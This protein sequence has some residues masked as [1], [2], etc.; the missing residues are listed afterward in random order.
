M[1]ENGEEVVKVKMVF[2]INSIANL[3]TSILIAFFVKKKVQ[4]VFEKLQ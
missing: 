4:G 1:C 2:G 3:S